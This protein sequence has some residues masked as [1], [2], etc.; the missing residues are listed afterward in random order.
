MFVPNFAIEYDE[1]ILL[2][3]LS[4]KIQRQLWGNLDLNLGPPDNTA[5]RL[6]LICRTTF[7]KSKERFCEFGLMQSLVKRRIYFTLT[8]TLH[9]GA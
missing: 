6:P 3:S 8:L 9:V 5:E 1:K 2:K 7:E 4:L